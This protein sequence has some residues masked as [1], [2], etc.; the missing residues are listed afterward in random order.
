MK[1]QFTQVELKLKD[2]KTL[3]AVSKQAA[4]ILQLHNKT[5]AEMIFLKQ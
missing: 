4:K 5:C 1:K 2:S 3:K